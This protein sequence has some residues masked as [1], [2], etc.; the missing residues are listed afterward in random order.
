MLVSDYFDI[1]TVWALAAVGGVL[2]I[3]MAASVV[4]PKQHG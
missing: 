1:P 3:S 4:N 2:L